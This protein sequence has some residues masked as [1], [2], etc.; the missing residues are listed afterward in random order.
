LHETTAFKTAPVTGPD[1]WAPDRHPGS[2]ARC[3]G[4]GKPSADGDLCRSCQQAFGSWLGNAEP[5]TLK[6]TAPPAHDAS[7]T[8]TPAQVA[9][10]APVLPEATMMS[11]DDKVAA[12]NAEVVRADEA[13]AET[14]R[15]E[16]AKTQAALPR[17]ARTEATSA[18][19]APKPGSECLCSR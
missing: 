2:D 1:H 9:L 4:C 7:D 6:S 16:E 13:R 18:E 5:S 3:E 15:T 17:G 12:A 11:V 14:V 19:K 10:S 8:T